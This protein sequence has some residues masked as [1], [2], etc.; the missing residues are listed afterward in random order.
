[1]LT[2]HRI[3]GFIGHLVGAMLKGFFFTG[4]AAALV[5]AVA[6]FLTEPNHRVTLDTS[7]AF[8]LVIAFL[9][10]VLARR[11]RRS[12]TPSHLDSLSP[13]GATLQA[14]ATWSARA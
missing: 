3:F 1:M 12:I 7:L 9:A 10:G 14:I 2:M 13:R 11:W 5:C 6:L 8:G 4:M